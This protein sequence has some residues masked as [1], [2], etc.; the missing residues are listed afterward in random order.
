MTTQFQ[1]I[2]DFN[3]EVPSKYH[4]YWKLSANLKNI[5]SSVEVTVDSY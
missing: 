1:N 2:V 4:M 5:H 3:V